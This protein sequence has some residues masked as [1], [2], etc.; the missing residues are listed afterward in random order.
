MTHICNPNYLGERT[1]NTVV[2]WPARTKMV[3]TLFQIKS[4]AW[5]YI[6]IISAI[7]DAKIGRITAGFQPI[8][9]Q[10]ILPKK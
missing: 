2:G 6:T 1:R 10:E 5:W 9:K 3:E 8:Q 4:R 7:S